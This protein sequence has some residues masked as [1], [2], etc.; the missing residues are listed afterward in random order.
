MEQSS[1]SD[2]DRFASAPPYHFEDG[3]ALI[4]LRLTT[5]HQLFNSIDPSPFHEKDLD[6][7]AEDYIVGAAEELNPQLAI[8]IV[9]HV[10]ADQLAMTEAAGME[11][12]IRNYFSYRR[13][14]AQR[15]LRLLLRRGRISLIV[16]LAFLALCMTARAAIATITSG[17]A[18]QVLT[19][20]ILIMGWV[21]L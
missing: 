21:A 3:V 17:A 16:G 11:T 6:P 8:K 15:D 19:E 20:G 10:P 12:A 5:L 14:S 13:A 1:P 9:L 18:A 7:D 4:E 2:S